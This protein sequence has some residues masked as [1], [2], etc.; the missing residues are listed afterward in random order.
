MMSKASRRARRRK[1]R[2][3]RGA[4]RIAKGMP[5]TGMPR[6]VRLFAEATERLESLVAER[7]LTDAISAAEAEGVAAAERL[8]AL[9]APFD[10]FDVVALMQV[11]NLV[12][13]PNT[14][15]ESEFEGMAAIIEVVALVVAARGDRLGRLPT[16]PS[17]RRPAADAIIEDVQEAAAECIRVGSICLLLRALAERDDMARISLGAAVREVTLRNSAYPHMARETL[18]SLFGDSSVEADC[19]SV[20]GFTAADALAI[21]EECHRLQSEAWTSR[22]RSVEKAKTKLMTALQKAEVDLS[23]AQPPKFDAG[24]QDLPVSV[25]HAGEHFKEVWDNAWSNPG[26]C[27]TFDAEAIANRTG[28]PV[29]TVSTVFDAFSIPMVSCPASNVV[30]EFV[31]GNSPLR[32]AP[33]LRDRDGNVLFIHDGLIVPAVRDRIETSLKTAGRF[34]AYS[35]HRGEIVESLALTLLSHHLPRADVYPSLEYLVPD[36][37]SKDPQ[38]HPEQYTKLVEG[39]GLIVV[40]DVAIIVEAKAVGM[41]SGARAGE[42]RALRQD[43]GRIITSAAVQAERMRERIVNDRGIKLRNGDWLDLRHVRETHTVTVSLEDL[44][45]VAT[46][47]AELVDAELL[48]AHSIPWTVSLHDLRVISELIE[49]PAE[50]VVYLRRRTDPLATTKFIAMDELDMFLHFYSRGLWVEPDPQVV[51]QELPHFKGPTIAARRRHAK[52]KVEVIA[53]QTDALDAWYFAKLGVRDEPAPKPTINTHPT[54]QQLAD[55]IT[56]LGRPGWLSASAM[57]IETSASDQRMLATAVERLRQ[58]CQEDGARHSLTL[59]YGSRLADSSVLTLSMYPIAEDYDQA[60]QQL[61]QYV[62][63]KKH[64]LQVTR[65]IGLL[66]DAPTAGLREIVYDNRT[67]GEDQQLDELVKQLGL[68]TSEQSNRSIPPRRKRRR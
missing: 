16:E 40:D 56:D 36:P 42:I 24:S 3:R 17:G 35:K 21:L 37:A 45:S 47:T 8:D 44:S 57:M 18:T 23:H 53:S 32:M 30:T 15:Q 6:P 67:P 63:V 46:V 5:L 48:S 66:F 55:T 65:G 13:D 9:I 49:R 2:E 54:L 7:D 14:Y 34:D 33:L 68:K 64:Q 52:Q 28:I 1:R 26:D 29:E 25:V 19:R 4:I 20:L 27:V 61:E 31:G 39:D 50:L 51:Q 41:R 22:M 43:L 59:A 38:D 60:L 62:I 58:M 12:Y 11:R 10:G